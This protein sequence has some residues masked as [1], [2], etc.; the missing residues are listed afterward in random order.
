MSKRS[1]KKNI[2]DT[3][4]KAGISIAVATGMA[5]VG[6]KVLADKPKIKQYHGA[7]ALAIG[8]A[9]EV[10]VD[11]EYAKAVGRGFAVYGGMRVVGD[12]VLKEDKI[13]MGLAGPEELFGQEAGQP[14]NA[15]MANNVNR[16]LDD[17][18]A[19]EP[20]DDMGADEFEPEMAALPGPYRADHFSGAEDEDE[21]LEGMTARMF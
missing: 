21:N 2:T 7:A 3:L 8:V 4:I 16:I 13:K 18:G 12:M 20:D 19:Y 6:G 10:F 15:E 5:F 9:T 17:M 11:N 1:K 14:L